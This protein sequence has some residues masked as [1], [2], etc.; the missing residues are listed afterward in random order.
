MTDVRRA[1]AFWKGNVPAELLYISY[2]AIQFSVYRLSGQALRPLDLPYGVESF[3]S[4]AFAG[5]SASAIT[6]PLDLLRTRFAAQGPDRVYANFRSSVRDIAKQE[7]AKGFFQGVRASVAQVLPY[8]GLFFCIYE[9]LR[10]PMT[11]LEL[12]LGSSDATAGMIASVIAKTGVFPL[13]V[14]R[15]RLQVQGPSRLR[16]GGGKIPMYGKGVWKTGVAIASRE[17]WRALYKG[18]AIGLIKSAPTSAITMW[19]YERALKIM[20]NMDEIGSRSGQD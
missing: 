9:T 6:Y 2:G 10:L 4:G 14:I 15:K 12:P 5:A 17:G 3:I 1:K 18:L 20:K 13:D 16:Y 8:M 19:T 7:G 11:K